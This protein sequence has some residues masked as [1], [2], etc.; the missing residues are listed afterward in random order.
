V[1]GNS[2]F[3]PVVKHNGTF[4]K[5]DGYCTDVF[6]G[7]A[8]AWIGKA[9]DG[10]K[11]F[12]TCITPNAPHG[13]LHVPPAYEAMYA[14]KAEPNAA[15]FFG[16]ITN[17]DDNVGRLLAKLAEWKIEKDTLVIFINDNGGTAG[18]K[19]WNAGMR[20]GKGTAFNGGTR[21]MSLWRW[22]GTIRPGACDRLTAHLDVFP[23]LAELAG[24]KVPEEAAARLEGFSLVPLLADPKA[25]WH[26]DRMLVTHVG[27]WERGAEPVK[28]GACSVRWRQY[29]QVWEKGRWRLYDLRADPGEKEDV[30]A[31]HADVVERLGTAYDAWW[32]ETLPCLENEQA[33][34]TAPEVNPFKAQYW[35][36]F[37]GPGPNN[38]PPG[39]GPRA[40]GKD[41]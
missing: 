41:R 30:A 8:Q 37:D 5:T 4:V 28:H 16:M 21:A 9:K 2:Y 12:F 18:L 24:A 11:P 32:T 25:P 3:G 36:Q 33:W 14:G 22:P 17:I 26:E 29:L 19:V 13:P 23:T 38:V 10:G 7:Q 20:G 40:G 27:R 6:F 15:K 34:K 39:G 1:P 31:Q 35:K